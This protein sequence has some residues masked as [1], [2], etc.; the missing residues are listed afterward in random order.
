[1]HDKLD[2]LSDSRRHPRFKSTAFRGV[3]VHL[4]PLP[5]YF[6]TPTEG[7]LVDLSAGGMAVLM[8]ERIPTDT[9]LQME[10]TFPDHSVLGC[11]VRIRRAVPQKDLTLIGIEFL[12][13]PDYMQAKITR[14]T[15]DFL[16]CDIRIK[17]RVK[18]ICQL[19]CAFFNIC[20]KRE[21][22]RLTKKLDTALK[23]KLKPL[24]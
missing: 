14:M 4:K 6:G 17:A 15:K 21:K 22:V 10:L 23:M 24:D 2:F 18:D 20:D 9:N 11:K 19:D 7:H 8:G 1:M 3:P 5:P 12:D 13:L 16:D